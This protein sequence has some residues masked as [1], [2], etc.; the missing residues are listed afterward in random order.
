MLA[1]DS[2]LAGK[3][4]IG[5][6]TDVG[7]GLGFNR[8]LPN[9]GPARRIRSPACQLHASTVNGPQIDQAAIRPP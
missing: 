7:G 4:G 8:G 3:R 5:D 2:L 1:G 6:E 9:Q